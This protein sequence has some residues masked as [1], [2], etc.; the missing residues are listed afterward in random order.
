MGKKKNDGSR[1][2]VPEW[3]LP[4]KETRKSASKC[5]EEDEYEHET[6]EY[7]TE[8]SIFGGEKIVVPDNQKV[9]NKFPLPPKFVVGILTGRSYT[10]KSYLVLSL[11]PNFDNLSHVM[12]CSKVVGNKVTSGVKTWCKHHGIAF[13]FA[14]DPF[15]G[16]EIIEKFTNQKPDNK[17]GVI[18]FDDYSSGNVQNRNDPYN[19]IINQSGQILRNL[20]WNMISLCQCYSGH[21]MLF[22]N[23]VNFMVTFN[24][25]GT[26]S[27]RMASQNWGCLTGKP[28]EAFNTL[29]SKMKKDIHSY[30]LSTP[31]YTYLYLPSQFGEKLEQVDIDLESSDDEEI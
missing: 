1:E 11:L 13:G 30:I 18:I 16:A 2:K 27:V 15:K 12:Y 14:S 19:Q 24:M 5:D 20:G 25:S 17:S 9:N 4:P 22:R 6:Y 28:P 10:G 21:S 31:D 23:N 3:F 29:Y 8:K 7:K 26:N